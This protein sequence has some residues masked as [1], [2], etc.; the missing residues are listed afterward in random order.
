[1]A[2]DPTAGVAFGLIVASMLVI[3]AVFADVI[4]SDL[5]II[6]RI[7]GKTW[8]L[9]AV[10]R[11]PELVAMGPSRIATE[12]S[13]KL[14]TLVAHGATSKA[15]P[16]HID[17]SRPDGS[18]MRVALAPAPLVRPLSPGH[19]L[20]TDREGRDV[21]ARMVH[22]TR[23]YLVFALVVPEHFTDQHLLSLP[24]ASGLLLKL[25]EFLLA[26]AAEAHD[27]PPC[28]G[29]VGLPI[30]PDRRCDGRGCREL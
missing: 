7:H 24:Q 26:L 8:L 14:D 13:W 27:C 22:G 25:L 18:K 17:V 5:P 10:T 30:L 20:G 4:A 15:E 28:R 29:D 2:R 21:L 9:P 16:E 6:C 11:P 19:L 12:A 3:V 23:S 1:M